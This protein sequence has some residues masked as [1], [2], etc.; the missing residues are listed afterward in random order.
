MKTPRIHKTKRALLLEASIAIQKL[1]P[2]WTIG[3]SLDFLLSD[4]KRAKS[5]ALPVEEKKNA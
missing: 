2:E 3:Q 5:L 4:P 1:R